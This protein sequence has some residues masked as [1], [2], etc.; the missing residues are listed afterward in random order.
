LDLLVKLVPGIFQGPPKVLLGCPCPVE[1]W[2]MDEHTEG[3]AGV[4]F[5]RK[6]F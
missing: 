1:F 2:V 4:Y 5:R 6:E 3:V